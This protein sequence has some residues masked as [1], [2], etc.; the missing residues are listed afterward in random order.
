MKESG[1]YYSPFYWRHYLRWRIGSRKGEILRIADLAYHS[2]DQAV[3]ITNKNCLLEIIFSCFT[4][5]NRSSKKENQEEEIFETREAEDE[6]GADQDDIKDFTTHKARNDALVLGSMARFYEKRFLTYKP[7]ENFWNFLVFQLAFCIMDQIHEDTGYVLLSKSY[8]KDHKEEYL[9]GT[10]EEAPTRFYGSRFESYDV[11]LE[12][13]EG[14][15]ADTKMTS[16]EYKSVTMDRYYALTPDERYE[17]NEGATARTARVLAGLMR[18]SSFFTGQANNPTRRNYMHLFFSELISRVVRN[19]DKVVPLLAQHEREF[20]RQM[21]PLFLLHTLTLQFPR[22]A[23]NEFYLSESGTYCTMRDIQLSE[24]KNKNVFFPSEPA[25]PMEDPV[26]D[27]VLIS[28]LKDCED[29]KSSPALISQNRGYFEDL[30]RK[31]LEAAS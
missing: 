6:P 9:G 27:A 10:A 18:M 23:L 14:E 11:P 20:L 22:P 15:S 5:S 19:D 1:S 2:D 3:S 13:D 31:S 24:L 4:E 7:E 21:K 12:D 28:Y 29:V 16:K 26:L 30:M 8:C 17:E 25:E